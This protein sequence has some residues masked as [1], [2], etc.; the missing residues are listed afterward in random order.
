MRLTLSRYTARLFA[1][2]TAGLLAPGRLVNALMIRFWPLLVEGTKLLR[3]YFSIDSESIEKLTAG[4][5]RRSG[6]HP[7]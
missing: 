7:R 5:D 2:A 1:A 6:W 3:E 4:F